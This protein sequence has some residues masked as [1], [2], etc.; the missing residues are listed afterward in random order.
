MSK[1]KRQNSKYY[2]LYALITITACLEL[3]GIVCDNWIYL[4]ISL[5]TLIM[6]A[7]LEFYLGIFTFNST[8]R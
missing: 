4:M 2:T 1:Y 8:Y 6:S 3:I 7:L 5:C